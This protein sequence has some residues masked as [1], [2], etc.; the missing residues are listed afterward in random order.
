MPFT[1]PL[2]PT[3]V[4]ETQRLILRPLRLEDAPWVQTHFA[5]WDIVRHLLAKVPWPYPE[6]GAETNIRDCLDR[7]NRGEALY[8][9]LTFKGGNDELIGRIDL[10]PDNGDKEM[11]GFWLARE[12]W[13]QGLM[14]EAAEAVTA[15]AF[16]TLNWP[17]IYVTNASTNL[18]S[19]RIK[20][21]QG[22]ELVDTVAGAFVEGAATKAV[23]ILTADRW[24]KAHP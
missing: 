3:P 13:G 23:W 1:I 22:F 17:H 8:W 15:Y 12:H 24:R 10:R 16:T 7:R 20:E 14:T 2:P 21:K 4:L 9:A 6:D 18:G 5:H 19:H 11:R